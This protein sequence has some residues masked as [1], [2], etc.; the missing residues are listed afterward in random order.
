MIVNKSFTLLGWGWPF[1]L[2]VGVLGDG[3]G[4]SWGWGW[5]FLVRVE[6]GPSGRGRPFL[7]WSWGWP[8]H[9]LDKNSLRVGPSRGWPFLG[10]PFLLLGGGWPQGW[11]LSRSGLPLPFRVWGWPFLV[12]VEVGPSGRGRPFLLGVGAGRRGWPFLDWPFPLLGLGLALPS[13]G[14]VGQLCVVQ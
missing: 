13:C 4:R 11:P 14:L 12:R 8:S 10:W 7:P 6:V 9:L 3:V 1:L 2:A 5:P